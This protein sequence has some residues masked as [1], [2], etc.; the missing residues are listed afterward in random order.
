MASRR[1]GGSLIKRRCSVEVSETGAV[2][3][4]LYS[5]RLDS[6]ACWDVGPICG[7]S[8][9]RVMYSCGPRPLLTV[10]WHSGHFTAPLPPHRYP[11]A[12]R[13]VLLIYCYT[14]FHN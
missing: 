7:L 5:E 3:S 1:S 8:A 10:P 2:L 4:K 13:H 12:R 11:A 14:G 6:K 9:G